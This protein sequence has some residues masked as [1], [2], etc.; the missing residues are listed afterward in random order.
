MLAAR[1]LGKALRGPKAAEPLLAFAGSSK[2]SQGAASP[3]WTSILES[4]TSRST[5]NGSFA[6]FN[7]SNGRDKDET[8]KQ[9]PST[10]ALRYLN[11]TSTPPTSLSSER[12]SLSH[13]G[14]ATTP[15]GSPAMDTDPA[16]GGGFMLLSG[17]HATLASLCY[18]IPEAVANVFFPGAALPQ[19]MQT[20]V[21]PVKISSL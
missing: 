20:Q 5:Y 4:Y 12:A 1:A 15:G 21:R 8:T 2:A 11:T 14:L 13:R 3:S 18:F 19:G 10:A 7:G 9:S 17:A 16:G 6:L